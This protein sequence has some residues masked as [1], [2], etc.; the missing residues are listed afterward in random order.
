MC[1]IN[2]IY[3]IE[4]SPLLDQETFTR[5]KW[6]SGEPCSLVPTAN[7][8]VS[9]SR[10]QH[11]TCQAHL[12]WCDQQIKLLPVA[13]PSKSLSISA[14][15]E[16]S[17]TN[18]SNVYSRPSVAFVSEVRCAR[19]GV[20]LL[21]TLDHEEAL[22][23]VHRALPPTMVPRQSLLT[24]HLLFAHRLCPVRISSLVHCTGCHIATI[25]PDRRRKS[26][27]SGNGI[28]PL[29]LRFVRKMCFEL[30][31]SVCH[32]GPY[33]TPTR[34]SHRTRLSKSI[35]TSQSFMAYQHIS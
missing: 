27:A 17:V 4:I 20:W 5:S 29:C 24:T 13:L 22:P 12:Y 25:P 31:F 2:K 21:L 33:P 1:R 6:H 10:W 14:Q 34:M 32:T 7:L 30:T 18:Q 35:K 16:W 28:Q 8:R 26:R 9:R 15:I 23:R 11:F 3:L 19:P